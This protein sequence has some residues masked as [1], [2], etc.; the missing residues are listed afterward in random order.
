VNNELIERYCRKVCISYQLIRI[1]QECF[2]S[3]WEEALK[4]VTNLNRQQGRTFSWR[5]PNINELESLV[6]C[7]AH[8]PSLPHGHPF[9]NVREG[10]WSSTT[11][12]FEPDWAW[13][14]YLATVSGGTKYPGRTP[15]GE[16]AV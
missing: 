5:M 9:R 13:A 3:T 6:D 1:Q 11:S 14:L 7:G 2:R 12:M 15:Y 10:Y 8:S 4:A 16:E